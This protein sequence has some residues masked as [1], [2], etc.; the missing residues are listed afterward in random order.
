[1][2]LNYTNLILILS[3]LF[4]S[5]F[6]HAFNKEACGQLFPKADESHPPYYS[7]LYVSTMV[8]STTSYFSSIGPC[9]MYGDAR[10]MRQA[11]VGNSIDY[12]VADAAQGRGEYLNTLAELSG[13]P[14]NKYDLFN[15]VVQSHYSELF[16]GLTDETNPLLI[17]LDAVIRSNSLLKNSCWTIN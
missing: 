1:M 6:A 17:K 13:C 12:L 2:I 7:P 10:N 8:P 3:L 9:S 15:S 14:K 5:T 16:N 4:N 11:F